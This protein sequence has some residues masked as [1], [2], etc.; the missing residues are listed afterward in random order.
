MLE[1]LKDLIDVN[2]HK[3]KE[4]LKVRCFDKWKNRQCFSLLDQR[5]HS[6]FFGGI[7]FKITSILQGLILT[8][9]CLFALCDDGIHLYSKNARHFMVFLEKRA[10]QSWV[11]S[12]V[13]Y[14]PHRICY[15]YCYNFEEG[16]Y[17]EW[18]ELASLC[19]HS[20]LDASSP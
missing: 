7:F 15:Y 4:K 12:L 5:F 6:S 3:C 14:F 19:S 10:S 11:H 1:G 13:P 20:R 9:I 18:R 17:P 16:L 8:Y 2:L